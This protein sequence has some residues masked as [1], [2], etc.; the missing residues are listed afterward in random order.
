MKPIAS[1][2][3]AVMILIALMREWPLTT[4]ADLQWISGEGSNWGRARRRAK[5]RPLRCLGRKLPNCTPLY[6]NGMEPARVIAK[7]AARRHPTR[8]RARRRNQTDFSVMKFASALLA[9]D[10]DDVGGSAAA[11]R[12]GGP[13]VGDDGS[14]D[15]ASID[16]ANA[17]VG[18]F[19]ARNRKP[20][21][22]LTAIWTSAAWAPRGVRTRPRLRA[23]KHTAL[24]IGG[25]GREREGTRDR[26]RSPDW[27]ASRRGPIAADGFQIDT[28]GE[29]PPQSVL[30]S[31]PRSKR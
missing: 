18:V 20:S 4:T 31:R 6:G 5:I 1:K 9:C 25:G 7:N 28:N 16:V 19:S 30:V 26:A 23:P 21:E 14:T 29:R 3:H 22:P 15:G 8:W 10:H 17:A 27:I 24:L 12:K 11:R 13:G 2:R